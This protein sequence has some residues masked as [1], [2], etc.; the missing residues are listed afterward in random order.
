MKKGR[1]LAVFGL[2]ILMISGLAMAAALEITRL[3]P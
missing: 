1:W 2:G 3:P